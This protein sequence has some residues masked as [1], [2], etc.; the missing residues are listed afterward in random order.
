MASPMRVKKMRKMAVQTKQ[1]AKHL[2]KNMK[3]IEIKTQT[4]KASNSHFQF[5]IIG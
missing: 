3:M 4:P 1:G 2:R 5:Y